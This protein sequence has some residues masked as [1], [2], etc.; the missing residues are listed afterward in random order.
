MKDK[1]NYTY[2][3]I[4]RVQIKNMESLYLVDYGRKL[5]VKPTLEFTSDKQGDTSNY[6]YQWVKESL[7][8]YTPT[9]ITLSIKRD[10]DTA[11]TL[12]FGLYDMYY[13]V[14]D[15]RTGVFTDAY[16]KLSVGAPT[17]E[18]WLLLCDLENGNSRLDMV[19]IRAAKVTLYN[20]ILKTVNSAYTTNGSPAFVA[21]TFTGLG[22]GNGSTAVFIGTNKNAA[23]LGLDTFDYKPKYDMNQFVRSPD[24]IKD[25][26]NARLHSFS[27]FS[28]L[29]TDN[30]IYPISAFNGIL[31][32]V[33]TQDGNGVY[34]KAS[35]W[36]GFKGP[37]AIVFNETNKT[38]LRYSGST[39]TTCL[40]LPAGTL[41]NFTTDMDLLYMKYVPY[42]SG[43]VFA[44][45]ENKTTAKRYL[46]R[47]TVAGKQNYF[48]EITG[49]G[50]LSAEH[51]AVSPDLGYLF[52][53]NGN[54]L[55]EYDP[56][57][58]QSFLM[59]DY[60]ARKISLLKFLTFSLTLPAASNATQ[61]IALS[62]K[63]LVST[64]DA[65]NLTNSGTLDIYTVPEINAPLQIFQ[66]Y[67]G[68]GKV[69]DIAYRER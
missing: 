68:T 40:T 49:D 51:F 9:P 8:G 20:D 10:L 15:K 21:T 34:F 43:E 36:A 37:E 12:D 67:T 35:R 60:G 5:I 27:Y 48:S 64:Y 17:Y 33:N 24:P 38:F 31:A 46:A 18:G 59:K 26:T 1:G 50:I 25:W 42:N 44:V 53:N 52:Y 58:K 13:R 22:P 6:S 23:I 4:N 16:F 54:K 69:T 19:S 7:S 61:Y 66:T 14:T 28:I 55:Y 39:A 11:I 41:F 57:L 3:P 30:N 47:F 2:N 32:P 56:V 65:D 62:K 45:L 63:L 29:N